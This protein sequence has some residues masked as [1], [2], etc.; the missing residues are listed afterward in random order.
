MMNAHRQRTLRLFSIQQKL[1]N[2]NAF[3]ENI[4]VFNELFNE[5]VF[6]LEKPNIFIVIIS[7]P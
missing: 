6:E 4:Y 1:F 7:F 3:N 5:N 2:E